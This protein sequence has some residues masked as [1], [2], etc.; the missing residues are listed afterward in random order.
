[1]RLALI[2]IVQETNDF[3][4][5]LTTLAD[6]EA[7]GLVEGEEIARHFGG[8]GQIGGHYAAVKESGLAI[9]TIP[10]IRAWAVAGGR[11]SREAFDFFQAKIRAGLETVGPIDGLV[12]HLHGACAAEGIDDVEGE[13]VKPR[14]VAGHPTHTTVT[15][16]PR[17]RSRRGIETPCGWPGGGGARSVASAPRRNGET[18]SEGC[19]AVGTLAPRHGAIK[20]LPVTATM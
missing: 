17:R 3:N 5:L 13:L 14:T 19:G 9:E 1:M 10:I 20:C 4:P 2:H 16:R 7:F 11:I 8:I 15:T 6:F 12:L 18:A